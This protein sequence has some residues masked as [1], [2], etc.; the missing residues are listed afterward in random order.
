MRKKN[1]FRRILSGALGVLFILQA[2]QEPV[3]AI[4]YGY[5]LASSLAN[6]IVKEKVQKLKKVLKS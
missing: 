5:G 1:L 4:K 2:L 3:Y 6:G